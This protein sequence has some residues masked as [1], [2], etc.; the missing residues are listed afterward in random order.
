MSALDAAAVWE[1]SRAFIRRALAARNANDFADFGLWTSL[2]LE[3]LGKAMLADIHPALIVDPQKPESLLVA[4]GIPLTTSPRTI[5]A[6]TVF[7]RLTLIS[8][9][10]DLTQEKICLGIMDRRNAHLHSGNWRLMG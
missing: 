4:C 10:F 9:P 5:M 1:K 8:K 7:S 2:S 3:M 6:K